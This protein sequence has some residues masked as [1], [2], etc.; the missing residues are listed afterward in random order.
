MRRAVKIG[1]L[2]VAVLIYGQA[3]YVGGFDAGTD[4][5]LCVWTDMM[6]HERADACDRLWLNSPAMIATRAWRHVAGD[7]VPDSAIISSTT[8]E[9]R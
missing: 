5:S 4:T 8:P 6:L 7:A 3:N 2:A 9:Q 1:A